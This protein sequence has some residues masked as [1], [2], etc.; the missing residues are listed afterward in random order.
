MLGGGIP[1][2]EVTEL[3][4]Q[5]GIGKTQ[6]GIQLAVDTQIPKQFGGSGGQAVYIDTEG[7]FMVERVAQIAQGL[8]KHLQKIAKNRNQEELKKIA[9]KIFGSKNQFFVDLAKFGSPY[10]QTDL[11]I[12]FGVKFCSRYNYPEVC[13]T[14]NRDNE[15]LNSG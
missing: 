11:K 7:S 2:C 1:C 15:W 8:S 9:D 10:S 13:T 14:Q 5:P 4:G 3:C 6:L 12:S